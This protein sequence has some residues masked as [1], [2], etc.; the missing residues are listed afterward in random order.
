MA[1]AEGAPGGTVR[2]ANAYR[3]RE[4]RTP[5]P[6]FVCRKPTPFVL[7]SESAPA[8]DNAFLCRAHTTDRTLVTPLDGDAAPRAAPSTAPS[9]A[10]GAAPSA[11]PDALA[12]EVDKVVREYHS[13]QGKAADPPADAP[14]DAAAPKA[15]ST[16]AAPESAD[17]ASALPPLHTRFALHREFFAQRVR[18]LTPRRVPQFPS[19]PGRMPPTT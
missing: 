11:A 6:C 19:V 5:R 14:A 1:G 18:Q 9:A 4:A 3:L 7:S 13:K 17:G 15:S 2:L 10:S 8:Y 12:A 16:N